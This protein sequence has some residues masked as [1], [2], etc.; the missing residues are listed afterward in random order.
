ME[1]RE[2]VRYGLA[3]FSV[4]A[5]MLHLSAAQDHRGDDVLVAMFVCAAW[6][7]VAWGWLV[8]ARPQRLVLYLGIALNAGAVVVWAL[9]RTIGIDIGTHL[10]GAEEVGLKDAVTVSF[11]LVALAGAA[12]LLSEGRFASSGVR[13]RAVGRRV[14]GLLAALVFAVGVPAFLASNHGEREGHANHRGD[15]GDQL[16][17]N[18]RAR[19][20]ERIE[21]LE[22]LRK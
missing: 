12:A 3:L 5:A 22:G 18:E 21:R 8:V 4:A 10:D 19:E 9:S 15:R 13:S 14:F 6:A 1:I 2:L 7:Q 16:S 17:G 20:L 11:E